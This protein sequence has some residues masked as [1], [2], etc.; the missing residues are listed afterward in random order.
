MGDSRLG[1]SIRNDRNNLWDCFIDEHSHMTTTA[2]ANQVG[3]IEIFKFVDCL[4]DNFF[5]GFMAKVLIDIVM[6]IWHHDYIQM[7][8][9][10]S[11][12]CSHDAVLIS[13]L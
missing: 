13:A 9:V 10:L 12:D 8:D 5:A 3:C 1:L 11:V 7:I 6:V 4:A 2:E